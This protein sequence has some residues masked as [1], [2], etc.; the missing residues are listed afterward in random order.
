MHIRLDILG[1]IAGD[2]FIA[3]VL[4]AWPELAD[5]ALETIRAAGVPA[6]IKIA[7]T[8][9]RDHV[10]VGKQFA[11]REP[12]DGGHSAHVRFLDIVRRLREAPLDPCVRERALA[13]FGLLAQAEAG[14]HG[15]AV[16]DVTFH[17][18]GAWDSIA[19]IVGAACILEAL[20]PVTW[21]VGPLPLGGG[22]VRTAHG[23]IAV[24]APATVA[25]L[26]G[27]VFID[28][29]I[30]GERVT[31]TGAAILRYL[32]T[33][34]GAAVGGPVGPMMLN[35]SGTGFGTRILPGL[36]NVL[37]VL[38][39]DN[40]TSARV[41]D[42]VG[43]IQF[44][45]DDQTAEDLAVGMDSLRAHEGVLDALQMPALGKK[46]RMV[47]H[48]QVLCR[49]DTVDRVIDACFFETTTIGLRWTITARATLERETTVVGAGGEATAVKLVRRPHG[50]T[51]A[52]ADVEDARAAV[53]H[54]E[55]KQRRSS[56]EERALRQH[57]PEKP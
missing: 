1:G 17:E 6:T 48:V 19:D 38:F 45:V 27:F 25:L 20:R 43:V 3:A 28:D 2:M 30:Q 14:V 46:G 55:R 4:D 37:R 35:R 33:T 49:P 53:G 57:D 34:L 8:D 11:V 24:P 52:K 31:P 29:K 50:R 36:S 56:A 51:S 40:A 18:L 10:L 42:H 15:V 21:S 39:F 5:D 23:E 41:D 54:D 9:H 7:L 16:D 13:I 22:R 47:C 32:H 26:Q 44:E 12:H